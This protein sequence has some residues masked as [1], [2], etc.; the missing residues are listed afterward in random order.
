MSDYLNNIVARS[1]GVADVVQPR[2]PQ[3]FEHSGHYEAVSPDASLETYTEHYTAPVSNQPM[4]ALPGPAGTPI[5]VPN[6]EPPVS[7]SA[8]VSAP[9]DKSEGPV[10][11]TVRRVEAGPEVSPSFA[12]EDPV[13]TPHAAPQTEVVS[14]PSPV[15]A[16]AQILPPEFSDRSSLPPSP[17]TVSVSQVKQPASRPSAPFQPASRPSAPFQPAL[18]TAAL[19]SPTSKEDL[20]QPPTAIKITIGRVDVRA[21]L[22]PAAPSRPAPARPKPALSLESYLKEREQGKR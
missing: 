1:I 3:L 10:A 5:T 20:E 2:L 18:P 22:P 6:F 21:M 12:A 11:F 13:V 8:T 7:P 9:V 17:K 16:H 19:P 14:V 15:H 4:E